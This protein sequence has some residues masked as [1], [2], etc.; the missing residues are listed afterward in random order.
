M[1]EC[2]SCFVVF[3]SQ[4]LALKKPAI[5]HV[6]DQLDQ[7]GVEIDGRFILYAPNSPPY[8]GFLV[9]EPMEV[10]PVEQDNS[11]TCPTP[12]PTTLETSSLDSSDWAPFL[13]SPYSTDESGYSWE[14]S[15][16]SLDLNGSQ[17]ESASYSTS[18]SRSCTI[19]SRSEK[20]EGFTS[21]SSNWSDEHR[22]PL[23][24][25]VSDLKKQ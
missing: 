12:Q 21:S 24:G 20:T 7:Y 15:A 18:E 4:D 8:P 6:A 5:S 23:F 19:S 14:E 17:F 11:E 16:T 10:E 25:L 13:E 3:D 9:G 22:F 2:S 1:S